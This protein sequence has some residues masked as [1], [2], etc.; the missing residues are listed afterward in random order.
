MQIVDF[1]QRHEI[2]R[3]HEDCKTNGLELQITSLLK[4]DQG[5]HNDH[6]GLEARLPDPHEKVK[7]RQVVRTLKRIIQ[8]RVI[9]SNLKLS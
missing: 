7:N 3:N 6:C 8:P 4:H 1:R 5:Q 9:L 2:L